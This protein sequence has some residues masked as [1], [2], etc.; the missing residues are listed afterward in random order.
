VVDGAGQQTR[1]INWAQPLGRWQLGQRTLTRAEIDYFLGFHAARKGSL[2]GFRFKDWADYKINNSIGVG[3]GTITE[4]Q[5]YK[6]YTFGTDSV[7]R[8]IT[9]PVTGLSILVDGVEEE[10]LEIDFSTGLV[11]FDNPPAEDAI[12]TAVG[13]FDV[14]VRFEQDSIN[15]RFV[16]KNLFQL[17]ALSIVEVRI[18]EELPLANQ[19][20]DSLGLIPL[21]YDFET[22][23]GTSFS[24]QILPNRGGFERRIQNWS[25][26][27][28]KFQVG[29]R[30]V[31]VS[32]LEELIALFRVARGGAVQF[33]YYDH[34]TEIEIPVRF[35]ADSLDFRF[36][37]ATSEEVGEKLFNLSGLPLIQ[38]LVIYGSLIES[39]TVAFKD[40]VEPNPPNGIYPFTITAP[41]QFDGYSDLQIKAYLVQASWDNR[42]ILGLFSNNT[43]GTYSGNYFIGT[44]KSF[45]AI[46]IQDSAGPCYFT[47]SIRWEAWTIS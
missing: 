27:L 44:G 13:T 25:V 23:G 40:T 36:D 43:L 42:A 10:D 14:P 47:G 1:I 15:F 30:V 19:I 28:K 35:E 16:A 41:S 34:Q 9:K 11:T 12:I 46:V 22:I 8:P 3:D 7:K 39:R 32:E 17:D 31:N 26:P 18:K 20:P 5:L 24:T 45:N 6:L 37:A 29:D 4:Y 38:S 21:N 2:E 33:R